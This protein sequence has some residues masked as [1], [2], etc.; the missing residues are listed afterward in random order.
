MRRDIMGE[1]VTGQVTTNAADYYEAHF[2]PALFLDRTRPLLELAGIKAGDTILD[3]G[4]G[5]GVLARE[6]WRRMNGD[7]AVT[8]IDRNDGMLATAS[9]IEPDIE[10]Q[11]GQAESLPFENASFDHVISQFALMFF[12]DRARSLSEMWRVTKPGGRLT[13]AVWDCLENTP[14][15][16]AMTRLDAKLFGESVANELLAPYSMGD[17]GA[18]LQ[19][20]EEAGIPGAQLSTYQ[21]QAKF[22]SLKAWVD[23]DVEGWTLGEMIGLE[24]HERLLKAADKELQHFVQGDGSVAFSSPSHIVTSIK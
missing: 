22:P 7:G 9:R 19:L 8:G 23:M 10:W 11:I 13:V 3:V 5:T 4:C 1:S 17:K 24:G 20:F 15:Y 2:V 16:A 18:L 14:G 12:E 6:A 21:G